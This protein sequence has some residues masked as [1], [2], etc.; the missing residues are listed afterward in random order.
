MDCQPQHA[1]DGTGGRS[2]HELIYATSTAG[3]ASA[4]RMKHDVTLIRSRECLGE[5]PLRLMRREPGRTQPALFVS[6]GVPDQDALGASVRFEMPP[7]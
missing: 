3:D 4:P 7:I 1:I 5:C 2:S 6:I